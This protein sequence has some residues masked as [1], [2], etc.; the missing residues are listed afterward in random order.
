M[1]TTHDLMFMCTAEYWQQLKRWSMW[2]VTFSPCTMCAI[3]YDYI[4]RGDY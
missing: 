1:K 3:A 2:L 4:A